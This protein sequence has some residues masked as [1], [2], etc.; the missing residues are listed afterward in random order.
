M[1]QEKA[2]PRGQPCGSYSGRS[3]P[4]RIAAT[5]RKGASSPGDVTG[6]LL[7]A[8]VD[9]PAGV[10]AVDARQ[11][12]FAAAPLAAYLEPYDGQSTAARARDGPGAYPDHAY[13][14]R[15]MGASYAVPPATETG[16]RL[17]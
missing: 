4:S 15:A 1:Y 5:S 14:G 13:A 16:V 3:A 7:G 8:T 11:P 2:A 6:Q 17:R 10:L 12:Y 9:D